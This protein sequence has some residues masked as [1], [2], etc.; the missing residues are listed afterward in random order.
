MYILPWVTLSL[1]KYPLHYITLH[2]IT[3]QGTI[4][5]SRSS[6]SGS[7][8]RSLIIRCWSSSCSSHALRLTLWTSARVRGRISMSTA[9]E[10][11]FVLPSCATL[12][13]TAVL[14]SM[15]FRSCTTPLF[16]LSSTST[17]LLDQPVAG[18][19]QQHRGST[20]NALRPSARQEHSNGVIERLGS[21]TIARLGPLK[22]RRSISC[23]DGNRV[24]SGRG[25]SL[26]AG[27]IQRNCGGT[28]SL[29]FDIRKKSRQVLRSS[30]LRPSRTLS[31]RS[32]RAYGHQLHRLHPRFS[33]TRHASPVSFGSRPSI[34]PWYYASSAMLLA[35]PVN[36]TQF[37]LGWSKSS[38]TN[39]RHSLQHCSMR[40]WAA[41][42]FRRLKR[43]LPSRQ[44]SR[45][46]LSIRTTSGTIDPSQT[47]R[48]CPSSSSVRHTNRLLATSIDTSSFQSCSPPTGNTDQPKRQQSRSCRTSTRRQTRAPSPWS[49]FSTSVRRST[50]STIASSLID[51]G[52]S[53]G[54]G[55]WPSS[56][57]NPIWRDAV[58][59]CGSTESLQGLYQSPPV[60][61]RGP[62]W[63]RS[64]LSRTRLQSSPS[65]STTASRC[66]RSLT[67]YRYTDRRLKAAPL[68][69]WLGCRTVSSLSR[70]GWAQI[71]YGSTHPRPSWFGWSPFAALRRSHN[72]RLWSWC[73]SGWVRSRSRCPDRQQHDASEPRQQRGWH[74]L[75][76]AT[77]A[78]H[79]PT[80]TDDGSCTLA[81]PCPHPHPSRLL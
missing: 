34:P 57:S 15:T 21:S 49:A 9:F 60:C 38:R 56:G 51:L 80:F 26:I 64:S 65:F 30:L 42:H 47:S 3:L 66:T 40:R 31:R 8:V 48:S 78:T 54:L 39:S 18:F 81:C 7:Q 67:T 6:T 59:S 76:P 46:R 62:S 11:N 53:T 44:S 50:R 45:R 22:R 32:W 58:N 13:N 41:A 70:H 37:L 24:N 27:A 19:S 14:R 69:W 43:L 79:H 71:D 2:Y 16:V 36:S 1:R 29:F 12:R 28:S 77:P 17:L 33:I 20:Q 35:S 75:L 73:P 5:L 72:E 4:S 23:T 61:R 68:T 52:T 63:G 25:K 74:L 10:A 55:D